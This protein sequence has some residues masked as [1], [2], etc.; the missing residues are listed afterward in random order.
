MGEGRETARRL[1]RKQLEKLFIFLAASPLVHARFAREF[2]GYAA[3]APGSTKPPCY[4][5]YELDRETC[6]TDCDRVT[7]CS[8]NIEFSINLMYDT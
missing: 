2:R 4:A 3:P 5:G 7:S 8:L 1:G 6:T